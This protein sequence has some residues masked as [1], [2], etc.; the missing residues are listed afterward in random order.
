M[1][2]RL[3]AFSIL[4]LLIAIFF[5]VSYSYAL[6]PKPGQNFVWVAPHTTSE[7]VFIKG[8]WK[9]TGPAKKG[10]VW[11]PGHYNP[12]GKWIPGHWKLLGSP[13]P[14]K[15]SVWVPGHRGPRGRWIP[16]HWR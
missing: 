1:F 5:I 6:P 10:K 2:N 15:G 13:K 3:N 8:H 11:V 4:F 14:F 12:N 16:G 7:G 9:Y